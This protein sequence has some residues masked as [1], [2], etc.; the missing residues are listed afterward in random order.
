M[1]RTL[2]GFGVG[3]AAL[4][5]A[6]IG[7]AQ[8]IVNYGVTVDYLQTGAATVAL[9]TRSA[10]GA[11]H[12]SFTLSSETGMD[13]YTDTPPAVRYFDSVNSVYS[14][15]ENMPF[16]SGPSDT[17]VVTA[18]GGSKDGVRFGS[19]GA[20][21]A[22]YPDYSYQVNY[23][24]FGSPETLNTSAS[25]IP[26]LPASTPQFTLTGGSWSGGA[27]QITQ[28]TNLGVLTSAFTAYAA[29]SANGGDV[30]SFL[31]FADADP[32]HPVLA[33]TQMNY[34]G[35]G[36]L[37]NF[38][39]QSITTTLLDPGAYT[40]KVT[41]TDGADNDA[42]FGNDGAFSAVTTFAVVNVTAV[43]EPATYAALL[44]LLALGLAAW[45]R[46]AG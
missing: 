33:L 38:F 24:L 45:R 13:I 43:P 42:A 15:A 39:N 22:V 11:Y 44:G 7:S 32:T 31:F 14:S 40:L 28:G 17:P 25:S 10:G 37:N 23:T 27:Y 12:F 36:A 35:A 6:V 30:I 1:H 41:F 21:Q 46:R 18:L 16:I 19:L 4:A 26:G 2:R 34:V 9:D 20:L 5:L 29:Q 8:A 3:F